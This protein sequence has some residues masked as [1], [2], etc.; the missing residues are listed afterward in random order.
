[1]KRWKI[2]EFHKALKTGCHMEE[3]QFKTRKTLETFLG[4]ASIISVMLLNLRDNAR[5]A[6]ATV[7][8]LTEIQLKILHKQYPRLGKNPKARDVLRAV[9]QMGGFMGRKSDGNPGWITLWRGMKELM[10]LEQGCLLSKFTLNL[11][12]MSPEI[13]GTL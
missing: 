5:D 6:T 4:L 11:A 8:G 2:E 3:H 9:A 10:L 7:H 1:M 12:S 13:A